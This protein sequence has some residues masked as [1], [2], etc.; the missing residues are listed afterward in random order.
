MKQYGGAAKVYGL[1]GVC[2]CLLTTHFPR[3]TP[4]PSK[5]EQ[6]YLSDPLAL[7]HVVITEQDVFRETRV[8]TECV[9]I[10]P[11]RLNFIAKGQ[12]RRLNRLTFGDAMTT[13]HGMVPFFSWI[14][15]IFVQALS[16]GGSVNYLIQSSPRLTSVPWYQ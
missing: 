8:F 5:D 16:T 12:P 15:L 11:I 14:P 1:F 10:L 7:R 6:V 3:L 9:E 13:V 4:R 2:I